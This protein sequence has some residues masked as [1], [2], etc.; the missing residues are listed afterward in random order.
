[1]PPQ[2]EN[3][4]DGKLILKDFFNL[5]L[6][7]FLIFILFFIFPHPAVQSLSLFWQNHGINVNQPFLLK[8]ISKGVF[9]KLFVI[10]KKVLVICV[11]ILF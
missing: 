3:P 4:T 11:F 10:F 9:L 1:M 7:A 6:Y 8:K 2:Q 5:D